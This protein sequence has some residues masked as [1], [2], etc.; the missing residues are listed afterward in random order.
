VIS[1]LAQIKQTCSDACTISYTINTTSPLCPRE[2]TG[3]IDLNVTLTNC[4]DT[5]TYVWSLNNLPTQDLTGVAA[6]TYTVTITVGTQIVIANAIVTD[7]PP[8]GVTGTITDPNPVMTATG[9]INITVTGGTAPYTYHWSF[10]NI[11]TEDLSSI[12]A[13]TY[14]VTVTDAHGCTFIPDDYVVGADLSASITSVTCNGICNGAINLNVSFGTPPYTFLWSPGGATT[15]NRSNLCAGIYCVTITDVL[16]STRDSCFTV[17]QPPALITTATVISDVN[18]DCH[19]AIDLNVTGCTPPYTYIWNNGLTSQDLINLCVGQYCV[20]ITCNGSGCSFD[21]CF[22]VNPTGFAVNLSALQHGAFQISCNGDCD[23]DINSTVFGGTAPFTYHWNNEKTTAH[24]GGVC[25]GTYSLT[26]T[27]AT[28]QT[29]TSSITLNQPDA[30]VVNVTK[31]FPSDFNGTDGFIS[32]AVSGGV[33]GYT[34]QWAPVAGNSAVLNNLSSGQYFLTVTDASGCDIT[35]TTDLFTGDL[36][37]KGIKII[38]PNSDGKNDFFV[39]SCI[40]N[41]NNHLSIYNR[42]GGLVYKTDNYLNNW[43]GVDQDNNPIA[44][45][46]YLW[47]LELFPNGA[48]AQ[49]YKGTV[50]VLRTA[51]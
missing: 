37:F 35:L 40:S 47:V 34:Y 14:S 4:T 33:P 50:N 25:A 28:G 17:T 36:C 5:P 27:D 48:T 44:D 26:V 46:G 23:G 51:D 1:G 29:A 41:I 8:L 31:T 12:P 11:A 2:A 20:T 45:G 15:Q 18:Q 43:T 7:P 21:T 38:T 39:I 19:G 13:G 30:I 49:I 16:G 6:G 22:N 32:V 24:I 3:S 42:F 10:N 9:A